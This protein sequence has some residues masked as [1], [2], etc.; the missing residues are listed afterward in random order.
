M[1]IASHSLPLIFEGQDH[2]RDP[3]YFNFAH[4]AHLGLKKGPSLSP[5]PTKKVVTAAMLLS[6]PQ[7]VLNATSEFTAN[8]EVVQEADETFAHQGVVLDSIEAALLKRQLV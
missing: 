7:E 4:E 2:D 1:A 5:L 6:L 8:L 3:A